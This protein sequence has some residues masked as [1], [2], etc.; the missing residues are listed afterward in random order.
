MYIEQLDRPTLKRRR[1]VLFD[2]PQQLQPSNLQRY[3]DQ[4]MVFEGSGNQEQQQH[5]FLHQQHVMKKPRTDN[6][7]E[8][9]QQVS[10]LDSSSST[11][12]E[13]NNTMVATDTS[14]SASIAATTGNGIEDAD[15]IDEAASASSIS[16]GAYVSVLMQGG[17]DE[18]DDKE[19][20]DKDDEDDESDI[21]DIDHHDTDDGDD[22]IPSSS[23]PSSSDSSTDTVLASSNTPSSSSSVMDLYL[24]PYA[25][26]DLLN[27]DDGCSAH[28]K[29][30]F[31]K[32][33]IGYDHKLSCKYI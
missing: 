10:L 32:R 24:A 5:L 4:M 26:L 1:P 8:S 29:G 28:H 12:F 31:T 11:T 7:M 18:Y 9:D 2:Q 21:D 27:M 23:F 30:R 13:L 33:D 17:E 3:H 22:T 16:W 14:T 20:G 6:Y 15:I 25:R 19:G